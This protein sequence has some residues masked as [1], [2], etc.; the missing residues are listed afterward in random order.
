MSRILIIGASG[1]MGKRYAAI[2][3]YHDR[4]VAFADVLDTPKQQA[5][6]AA[7]SDG[8]IV[9]TPTDTH[10]EIIEYL[11][12]DKPILCEKPLTK[13][14]DELD[15]M[16]KKRVQMVF[17]YSILATAPQPGFSMYDYYR[18]GADGL[19]WDCLQIIGLAKG[20]CH[21]AEESPI[22][23]CH[24]N[25]QRMDIA[26]MDAAYVHMVR[27]WLRHPDAQ[28]KGLI[29]EIHHKTKEYADAKRA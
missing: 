5:A 26:H 7:K 28:D 13:N 9:C 11:P 22:W 19:A 23:R 6:L 4:Q 1:N 3:K 29:R 2:L 20:E 15:L 8:V 17:Q 27:L 14:V 21:L 24:I 18:H 12:A 16:L 25:G 10:A